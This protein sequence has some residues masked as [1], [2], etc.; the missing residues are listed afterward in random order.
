MANAE[1]WS[2][3]VWRRAT[4]RTGAA[5]GLALALA[6]VLWLLWQRRRQRQQQ[7][8]RASAEWAATHAGLQWD[9]AGGGW[10]VTRLVTAQP[11]LTLRAPSPSA[12]SPIGGGPAL[13]SNYVP[14]IM[15]L[16]HT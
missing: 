15:A 4:D 14:A 7:H 8:T 2:A 12:G 10:T 9:A 1:P 6:V 5:P 3:L 16:V 13:S 11:L